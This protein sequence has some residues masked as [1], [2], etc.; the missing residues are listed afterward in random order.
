MFET[1]ALTLTGF[2]LLVVCLNISGMMQVRS[3]MRERELSIRQAIGATR[4]RLAQHLLAEAIVLAGMGSVLAS[5][6]LFNLP[7]VLAHLAP[8]PLPPQVEEALRVDPFIVA[9]CVALCLVASLMFG[10]IP[11]M[12]F[13]RPVIISALKEDAGAG[14]LRVGRVHRVTAALQVAIAVPLLVMGGISLDRVRSTATAD[15]GFDSDLLYSAPLNLDRLSNEDAAFR[16]RSLLGNLQKADGVSAV[17][18]ADGMPLDFRYRLKRVALQVEANVAPKWISAHVTR[19]GDGYLNTIG[20]S[21]LRGREFTPND[22][23]GAEPVTIISKALANKMFPDADPAEAIGKHLSYGVPGGDDPGQQTLTIVGI[24]DDFPTSQM[25]TEREQLLL[26]LAQHSDVQ[27][28]S[29]RIGS[30]LDTTPR[31]ML[32]A[33]STPDNQAAKIITGLESVVRQ[34]DPE[35]KRESIVTG[36]SARQ[37]SM[38]DFLVQ[39]TIAGVAGSVMAAQRK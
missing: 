15:L 37:N 12:R 4:G 1:V 29:V 13:S 17:T 38:R 5:L 26:P 36:L 10:F 39:S 33:R 27:R 35:F 9:I 28:D 23:P 30:D 19:V 20:T 31:L 6:V 21:L 25:S 11:A 18:V 14:G 3:A 34:S 32:I 2:V 8:S 16:I 22:V 24:S 7:T